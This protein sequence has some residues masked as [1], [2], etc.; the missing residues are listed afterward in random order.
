M[1]DPGWYP[2]TENEGGQ[3]YFDGDNWTDDRKPPDQAEKSGLWQSFRAWPLPGQ[4][5]SWI[6]VGFVVVIVAGLIGQAVAP[7]KPKEEAVVAVEDE[8]APTTV[9]TTTAPPTTAAPTTTID[10][11]PALAQGIARVT[12]ESA[13]DLAEE[14]YLAGNGIESVDVVRYDPATYTFEVAATSFYTTTSVR[15]KAERADGAWSL[16]RYFSDLWDA[17]SAMAM[18]NSSFSVDVSG[19]LFV[20]DNATMSALN[21]KRLSEAEWHAGCDR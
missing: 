12:A 18:T 6:V 3:R 15:S 13:G 19:D 11:R 14:A 8:S 21:E 9:P 16:A 5:L 20:C 2:D 10:P 7:P 17:D 1:T 4:I